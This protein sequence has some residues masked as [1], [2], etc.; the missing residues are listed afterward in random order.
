MSRYIDIDEVYVDP[1]TMSIPWEE[2]VLM[3]KQNVTPVIHAKWEYIP[4]ETPK[5]RCSNCKK[6]WSIINTDEFCSHCG[7]KMDKE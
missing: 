3:V 2:A 4:E 6:H 5:Y 7:A 1:Y